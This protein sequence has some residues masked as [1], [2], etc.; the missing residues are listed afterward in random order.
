MNERERDASR[1]RE[2]TF[3][4]GCV[5]FSLWSA[6]LAA[7]AWQQT[8][9]AAL[10]FPSAL[11]PLS[12]RSLGNI[13]LRTDFRAFTAELVG[14]RQSSLGILSRFLCGLPLVGA[15]F[16]GHNTF[17]NITFRPTDIQLAVRDGPAAAAGQPPGGLL[18]SSPRK[19][20]KKVKFIY[21]YM[22]SPVDEAVRWPPVGSVCIRLLRSGTVKARSRV[23]WFDALAASVDGRLRPFALQADHPGS[24]QP[25]VGTAAVMSILAGAAVL[26]SATMRLRSRWL[27]RSTIQYGHD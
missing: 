24:C 12:A 4:L 27:G 5:V 1:R 26:S 14:Q 6:F 19:V 21:T 22:Y 9:S 10:M 7:M 16:K 15:A 25:T 17:L 2:A 8:H 18:L 13:S 20:G 3:R 23:A 11:G